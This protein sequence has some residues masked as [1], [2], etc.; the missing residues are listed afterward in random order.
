MHHLIAGTKLYVKLN[1]LL[2]QSLKKLTLRTHAFLQDIDNI[3]YRKPKLRDIVYREKCASR[4]SQ[5]QHSECL[6][7]CLPAYSGFRLERMKGTER[8]RTKRRKWKM[9]VV[10]ACAC[11]SVHL[12]CINITW[13]TSAVRD[14]GHFMWGKKE[15]AYRT[16]EHSS[17]VSS[18]CCRFAFMAEGG[19][20]LVM[21]CGF[22]T[23]NW[24]LA[25][26]YFIYM[27][28]VL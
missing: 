25:N 8:E 14:K 4:L 5:R 19:E 20:V 10:C 13:T 22:F 6:T 9:Q 7:V 26:D 23:P 28:Y 11:G 24:L 15:K 18:V 2:P 17:T 16:K 1:Q 12:K 27:A 3:L 21:C